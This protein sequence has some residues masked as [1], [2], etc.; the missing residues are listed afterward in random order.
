MTNNGQD[1]ADRVRQALDYVLSRLATFYGQ[2]TD[3]VA[4][5]VGKGL[6]A[7]G[8]FAIEAV[9]NLSSPTAS[10]MVSV[11]EVR[12]RSQGDAEFN[13][14]I[15]IKIGTESHQLAIKS[16]PLSGNLDIPHYF[17]D[18]LPGLFQWLD[19]LKER[20]V[21]FTIAYPCSATDE[22]WTNAVSKA[23]SALPVKVVGQKEF[24]VPRPPL[25]QVKACITMW[26]HASAVTES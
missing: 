1:Q 11:E 21:L 10:H 9:T 23:E 20:A 18:E 16:M 24:V 14:D 2:K 12:G 22:A 5:F 8:W 3:Q 13:P 19:N 17:S 6:R 25:P 15:Q 26:R 4:M 7:E